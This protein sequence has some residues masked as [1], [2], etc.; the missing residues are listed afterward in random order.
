M[1]NKPKQSPNTLGYTN[2]T[3]RE[4][5]TQMSEQEKIIEEK[6]RKILE[7]M[8]A[9]EI[10]AVTKNSAAAP[11]STPPVTGKRP[12]FPAKKSKFGTH[13]PEVKKEPQKTAATPF[14]VNDGNFM[15]RFRQMQGLASASRTT[16]A[17][18]KEEKKD[19]VENQKDKDTEPKNQL[20]VNPL[21]A[22]Q[23]TSFGENYPPQNPPPRPQVPLEQPRQLRPFPHGRPPPPA[24]PPPGQAPNQPP[25]LM[26]HN[27]GPPGQRPRMPMPPRPLMQQNIEPPVS[28]PN[29]SEPQQPI[30][31]QLHPLRPFLQQPPSSQPM[32]LMA[33]QILPPG[34]RLPPPQP[35]GQ[36]PHQPPGTVSM[37]LQSP[38]QMPPQPHGQMPP[39]PLM[40]QGMPQRPP[41][42][43]QQGPPRPHMPVI[44]GGPPHQGA[45]PPRPPPPSMFQGQQHP[46]FPPGTESFQPGP[47]HPGL[48]R[49][50]F[51][52]ALP[53]PGQPPVVNFQSAPPHPPPE[54]HEDPEEYDP[55]EPTSPTLEKHKG[56]HHGSHI[57]NGSQEKFEYDEYGNLIDNGSEQLFDD[58][59]NPID[60]KSGVLFDD[61]GNPI[62]VKRE[63]VDEYDPSVPTEADSPDK[64]LSFQMKKENTSQSKKPLIKEEGTGDVGKSSRNLTNVFDTVEDRGD[65]EDK[66]ETVV[67]PPQDPVTTATIDKFAADVAKGGPEVE[68]KVFCSSRKNPDFWFLY[69]QKSDAYKYYR[70]KVMVLSGKSF[71]DNKEENVKQESKGK[72]RKSRWGAE[73]DIV[74][75]ILSHIPTQ[76]APTVTLEDFA[77]RMVGS[78]EMTEE[79]LKQIRE[80]QEMNMMYQL[81]IAQK[82]A[83]EAALADAQGMKAAQ[84]Y[85]Y[86]S[87]ED[88]EGGTWE[89]KQRTSEMLATREWADKLTES[90][91]GKHFIGDFLPPDE[92]E[93]FMETYK[94]LKDGREPDFSDYKEF[95]LTC[96]NVGYKML[97]KLGWKEGEGLGQES[98]GIVDPVNKGNISVEGRGLGIERPAEL[99]AED[100]E[101]D[102]YR[103]RMMLAYRFRPNP[104]NNPRRPYY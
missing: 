40:P 60:Q 19:N 25:L 104:L 10:A 23:Q 85:E 47:H 93:R 33:Q 36:M 76:H 66:K 75:P 81:I 54:H 79:Q 71:E 88:I 78:S 80:Q 32:P 98:Q 9:D 95:K 46:Q 64:T 53:Q 15:E 26:T 13:L 83:Q 89:H 6:K 38:D 49:P 45:L 14:F 31:Q 37:Q 62:K 69:E 17:T 42:N 70:Y 21:T 5:M 100:D 87:D 35:L 7:K 65:T 61:Y 103:K 22:N 41:L 43:I 12:G 30:L 90:N 97:E 16:A 24:R 48:P 3:Y 2:T 39:H 58:Y 77:R 91:K 102:A 67:F 72:K 73:D 27:V 96:E 84:K 34:H 51:S 55:S 86:D 8:K 11:T 82:K 29:I 94:A 63:S 44:P 74:P 101:F 56:K 1:S 57:K 68:V 28:S 99:G 20:Q 52:A 50:M 59:G 4:K 92:L 18:V